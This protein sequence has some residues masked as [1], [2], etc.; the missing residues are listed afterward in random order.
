MTVGREPRQDLTEDR[1]LSLRYPR[2]ERRTEL[3]HGNARLK[4]IF[5]ASEHII[6]FKAMLSS[7][8]VRPPAET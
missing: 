3:V 2:S 6:S 4:L 1:R 5:H 8:Q 7:Y